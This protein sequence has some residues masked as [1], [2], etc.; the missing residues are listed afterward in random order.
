[1]KC[2]YHNDM[3]GHCAGAIIKDAFPACEMI[4]M[5]YEKIF[6]WNVV[7]KGEMV[8]MVDFC[9]Q[10]FSDMIK[11]KGM[12]D[13]VWI[14]HHIT[15]INDYIKSGEDIL[16]MLGTDKAGCELT[17]EYIHN[18]KLPQAVELIGR[19]DVWDHS[20]KKTI[21]FQYGMKS[22]NTIPDNQEIWKELFKSDKMIDSICF[23]GK[24]ILS[25][26][27]KEN[28]VLIDS[29]AYFINIEGY[30]AVVLNVLYKNSQVFDSVKD[31]YDI[32]IC[33]GYTGNLWTISLYT[34]KDDIDVSI[35]AKKYGGGGHHNA[36]G[37]QVHDI[38]FLLN[39]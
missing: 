29:S 1:M 11:L 33:Y 9:L 21:P 36:A 25:Y 17:W 18:K 3:D 19:Y 14:D 2:Y 6:D 30:K 24:S 37:C 39:E 23:K 13:L 8:F 12:C 31:D 27:E 4:E 32:M 15:A 35:I 5:S 20:D 34:T 26:I 16:G 7:T 22:F 38:G 28:E 10:P